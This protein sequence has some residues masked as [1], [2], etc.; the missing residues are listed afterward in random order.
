MPDVK[1]DKKFSLRFNKFTDA[2][3]PTFR[4]LGNWGQIKP[5]TSEEAAAGRVAAAAG[6]PVAGYVAVEEPQRD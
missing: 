4:H 1:V 6:L 2:G 3:C 5:Y